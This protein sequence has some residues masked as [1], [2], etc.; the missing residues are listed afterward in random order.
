MTRAL[1]IGS[2]PQ[3]DLGFSYTAEAPYDAVVIGSLSLG[4]LL[5]FREER[6]LSALA[7]GKPV[8]LY[9]PG[10]PQSAQNRALA[11]SIAAAQRQLKNWVCCSQ[12]AAAN[13]SLPQ[14]KRS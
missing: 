10:M 3:T 11:G 6:T 7:E 14:K 13:T 2:A 8:Y 4:Q 1:L 5:C 12:T 9:A